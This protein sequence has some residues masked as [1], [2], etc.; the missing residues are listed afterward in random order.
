MKN[1]E[2]SVER[3]ETFATPVVDVYHSPNGVSLEFEVPGAAEGDLDLNV[4][5]NVLKVAA[6]PTGAPQP[7]LPLRHREFGYEPY[8][9]TVTLSDRLDT[10]KIEA[11]LKDGVLTVSIPNRVEPGA[12]KIAVRTAG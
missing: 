10:D 11:N 12:R 3:S 4:E 6:F 7:E 9:R 5:G 1:R 2:G 8:R